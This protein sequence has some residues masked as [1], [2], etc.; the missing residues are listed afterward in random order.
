[1]HILK[2]TFDSYE[3]NKFDAMHVCRDAHKHT[4]ASVCKAREPKP[5]TH[6]TPT[7]KSLYSEYANHTNQ[8][9]LAYSQTYTHVYVKNCKRWSPYRYVNLTHTLRQIYVGMNVC[10]LA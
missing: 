6:T 10:Y 4:Q 1:L 5:K 2:Q 8:Y 3:I 9:I 7:L